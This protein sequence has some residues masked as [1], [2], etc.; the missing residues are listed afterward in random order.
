MNIEHVSHSQVSMWKRCPRQWEYRYVY[1]LKEPPSGALVMGSCY[2]TTLEEQ[3]RQKITSGFDLDFDICYDI[4]DTAWSIRLQEEEIDWEGKDPGALKDQG[5]NLVGTYLEEAAPKV[6]PL[7]VERTYERPVANIRFVMRL[8][9]LDINRVIIDHKT[10]SRSYTQED[11]DRDQQAS[12]V[13][14]AM[15]RP[16]VFYNHVAVKTKVPK[17][18]LIKT[19]RTRADIEWY[20]RSA[21]QVVALMKTGIAPPVE[22]GWDNRHCN[23]RYCGYWQRCR[24][25]LARSVSVP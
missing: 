8:D 13:A 25:E 16:I 23:P 22:D 7:E 20:Q 15:D 9:I 3:F 21:E 18:Q 19:H 14:F 17:I 4:F 24:G 10:S 6:Q 1:G 5:L 11:I 12:A 2:H